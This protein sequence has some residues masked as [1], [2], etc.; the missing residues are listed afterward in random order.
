MRVS[1][2]YDDPGYEQWLEFQRTGQAEGLVVR[3]DEIPIQATPLGATHPVGLCVTADEERGEALVYDM[4]A[5][6]QII[7]NGDMP[8]FRMLYG[9]VRID[10][11]HLA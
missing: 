4:D 2:F 9:A 7:V 11:S 5:T 3:I 6:G 8:A 10:L 1:V